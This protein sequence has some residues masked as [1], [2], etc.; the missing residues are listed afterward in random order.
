MMERWENPH[1]VFLFSS[2]VLDLRM[3]LFDPGKRV[4]RKYGV[5]L[6]ARDCDDRKEKGGLKERC[7]STSVD[8]NH[9]PDWSLWTNFSGHHGHGRNIT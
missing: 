8:R 3:Q 6:P 7:P 9:H 1:L 4:I 2:G 5:C